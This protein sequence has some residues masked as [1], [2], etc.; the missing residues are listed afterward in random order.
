MTPL[1]HIGYHKTGTSWLQKHLFANGGAGFATP[2]D[3]STELVDWIVIPNALD[4]DALPCRRQMAPIM[5]AIVSQNLVPVITSERFCGSPHAG[6][7]DSKEIADRLHALFPDG[8][9]I[10]VLRE[11]KSMILS[12]YKQYVKGGGSGTL[13]DYLLPPPP[14][15]I[16]LFSFDH[17][18]YHRL[19]GYYHSVFGKDRVLALPFEMFVRTPQEFIDS[20]T[21]FAGTRCVTDLPFGEGVNVGQSPYLA[22]ARARWNFIAAR[23]QLNPSVRVRSDTVR[24]TLDNLLQRTDKLLP[25]ARQNKIDLAQKRT[26]A[27]IV[28]ERFK[29][30][31]RAAS[32]MIGRDLAF[33]GYDL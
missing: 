27:H 1:I 32:K 12:T 9:V 11:Q 5:E 33:Y 21:D 25:A 29:E 26:V 24:H 23:G 16:P 7:F 30:S 6:G 18:K 31:N 10:V 20:I 2:F 14:G 17:F 8:R 4:F 28:G 15:K 3:K 19:I 22:S 13:K